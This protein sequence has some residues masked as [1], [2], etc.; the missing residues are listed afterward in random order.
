MKVTRNKLDEAIAKTA[1]SHICKM[2]ALRK[3]APVLFTS[4]EKAKT[5]AFKQAKERKTVE[6]D[7][8]HFPQ[9]LAEYEAF[10]RYNGLS[11][12]WNDWYKRTLKF[13]VQKGHVR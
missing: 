3:Y 10:I 8:R 1:N 2:C 4:A 9:L 6:R 11:N 13:D 12:K 7:A 5:D